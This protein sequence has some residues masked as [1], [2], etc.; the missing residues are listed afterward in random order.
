MNLSLLTY[1]VRT[2]GKRV[3]ENAEGGFMA[4]HTFVYKFL[5]NYLVLKLLAIITRFSSVS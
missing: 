3:H 5:I 4:M 2:Y 1:Y